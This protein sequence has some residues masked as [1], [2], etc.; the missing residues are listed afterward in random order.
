MAKCTFLQPLIASALYFMF[1]HIHLQLSSSIKLGASSCGL[2][3]L[4]LQGS[5]RFGAKEALATQ[6]LLL[7]STFKAAIHRQED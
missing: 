4:N 1:I 2:H 6:R 7:L 5:T 3:V